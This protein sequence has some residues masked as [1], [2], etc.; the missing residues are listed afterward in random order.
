[1]GKCTNYHT[2]ATGGEDRAW[3]GAKERHVARLLR[4]LTLVGAHEDAAVDRIRPAEGLRGEKE[5]RG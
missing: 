1:M 2:A 4:A 5:E 3:I